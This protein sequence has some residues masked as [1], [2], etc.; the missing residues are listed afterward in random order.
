MIALHTHG[1]LFLVHSP[2]ELIIL[3]THGEFRVY[4]HGELI[5]MQT[6]DEL[7]FCVHIHGELNVV[8]SHC[9]SRLLFTLKVGYLLYTPMVSLLNIIMVISLPPCR[10]ALVSC[11]VE[12]P[13]SSALWD[14]LVELPLSSAYITALAFCPV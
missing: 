2:G 10:T 3:H 1:E 8:H 12:L 11:P 13:L 4:L 14:Y 9:E 7:F 6:Y 5:A